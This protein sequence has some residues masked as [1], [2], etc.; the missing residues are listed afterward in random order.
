M[1]KYLLITTGGTI[2]SRLTE[3][4]LAPGEGQEIIG[5]AEALAGEELE[6]RSLFQ[7]DS[8]N[9]QPEEWQKMAEEIHHCHRDYQGIVLTHGT[10]TMGYSASILSYMLLGIPIPVVLTGSQLPFT[11]PLSDAPDNLRLAFAVAKSGRSGVYVAFGRKVILGTRAVKVRT[12]GFN[13]FE[14][15]NR[16][17]AGTVSAAGLEFSSSPL[18]PREYLYRPALCREVFL[19]KLVPGLNP[20]IFDMLVQMDYKGVVVEA[21]G[22]GGL[23][24]IRR[25]LV[26]ELENLT[27]SGI[28]VVVVSQCLYEPSNFSLYEVGRRALEAGVLPGRDMTTEAA[29][30]KL[31]WALANTSSPE[32]CREMFQLPLAGEITPA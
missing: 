1:G 31:M 11:D 29:V 7:L 12:L 20:A 23:H 6:I 5:A 2:A 14:S 16:V 9:I 30:T 4:G 17:P 3:A 26:E 18:P 8:S 24:Y 28:L 25:N 19:L 32:E 15:V 22:A 27:K 13:A 10:D 21:F